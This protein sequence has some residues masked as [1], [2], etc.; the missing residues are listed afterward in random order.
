MGIKY[1][2]STKTYTVTYHR[3]HPVTKVSRNLKRVGI[4]SRALAERTYRELILKMAEKFNEN[5]IPLWP[6]AID[7]FLED[8][9][10]QGVQKSTILNYGQCLNFHTRNRW[11]TLRI[12]EITSRDIRDFIFDESV[13][14]SAA[15][16]KNMLKYIRAVFRFAIKEDLVAKDP[17]P[18]I[19]FKRNEKIKKMLNEK[20]A[21]ALLLAARKYKN[22]WYP[23]W[24][25]ALYTG[26]RNGEL[27]ALRWKNV[28]LDQRLMFINESW[29]KING[30]K[31]TKSGDDRIVEIA[32]SL[33][34]LMKELKQKSNS[35]YVLPRIRDWETGTQAKPLRAFLIQLGLPEIR[36]HDLRAS[37]A[38]IM[39]TKGVEPIKVMSMGGWKDLKTMQIYIRKSGVNIKGITNDLNF[40]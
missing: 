31:E 11:E 7:L 19:Q 10:N 5:L 22:P 9:A 37:W 35:E 24:T 4:K 18:R 36:F 12:N 39:L 6:K 26:L 17:C 1:I 16:Q 25:L 30:F 8:Y 33:L 21:R 2:E 3:R 23:I 20:E 34:P 38:T 27:F 13:N 14:L 15:H 29:N 28:N 40:L 32:T